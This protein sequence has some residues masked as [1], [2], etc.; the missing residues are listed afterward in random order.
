MSLVHDIKEAMKQAMR[1][2]NTVA[3]TALRGVLSAFTNEVVTLG[4][5]PSDEL[6]DAEAIVVL[7]R[8]VKKR[9]DAIEQFTAGGREDLAEDD[10]AEV[11]V[12]SE[13]IPAGMSLDAIREIV[14]AKKDEMGITDASKM[15][16]LIGAV[17]KETQ[18]QADGSDIKS[19]VESLFA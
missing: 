17:A 12:L 4:R 15:G 18:G 5:S 11:A 3:L 13:F 8:E 14:L 10:K 2:K 16:Q 6:Q 1:D 9:R 19:V 7:K